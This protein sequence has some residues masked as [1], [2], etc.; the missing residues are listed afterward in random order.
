MVGSWCII[1][2][3]LYILDV[4]AHILYVPMQ[5]D[6]FEHL[7]GTGMETGNIPMPFIVFDSLPCTEASYF[8][9]CCGGVPAQVIQRSKCF[10]GRPEPQMAMFFASTILL[11]GLCAVCRRKGF[12]DVAQGGKEFWLILFDLCKIVI[13]AFYNAVERFFWVCR[14][15]RVRI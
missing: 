12:G 10:L 6:S 13:A 5:T 4:M 14:A 11:I 3:E 15:S 7:F 8:H 9:D 1:F 2:L